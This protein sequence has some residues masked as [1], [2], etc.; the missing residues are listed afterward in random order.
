MNKTI[1]AF[2]ILLFL[3]TLVSAQ[4]GYSDPSK[5]KL[6]APTSNI[7]LEIN[8]T[9]LNVNNSDYLDGYHASAFWDSITGNI[10]TIT[11]Y[12]QISNNILSPNSYYTNSTRLFK[13]N[14][15]LD[16]NGYQLNSQRSSNGI[17]TAGY[18]YKYYKKLKQGWNPFSILTG[19]ATL[20][21]TDRN[22]TVYPGV[23]MIGYSSEISY[24]KAKVFYSYDGGSCYYE[25]CHALGILN[26]TELVTTQLS[27]SGMDFTRFNPSNAYSVE[28]S[29][30]GNLTFFKV[31]GDLTT[32][33]YAWSDLMFRDE[34]TGE[35]KNVTDAFNNGNG[36]IG[37][38]GVSDVGYVVLY[39][40][41]EFPDDPQSTFLPITTKSGIMTSWEG[42][43]IW[44]KTENIT[45]LRQDYNDT[46]SYIKSQEGFFDTININ[47]CVGTGCGSSSEM[48]YTNIAMQNQTNKFTSNQQIDNSKLNLNN[49]K[50]HMDNGTSIYSADIF[51]AT[52]T[53]NTAKS[54]IYILPGD[55][56]TRTG[57]LFFGNASHGFYSLNF[58]GVS[59]FESVPYRI[60]QTAKADSIYCA[61]TA[62]CATIGAQSGNTVIPLG[63][64]GSLMATDNGA[65]GQY[66]FAFKS[67]VNLTSAYGQKSQ[68]AFTAYKPASQCINSTREVNHT[69]WYANN[70]ASTLMTLDMNGNLDIAGNLT[71]NSKLGLTQDILIHNSTADDCYMNFT[72]GILTSTT[73]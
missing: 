55:T 53:A 32:D 65:T 10:S 20:D 3:I 70:G 73:C 63:N 56:S 57:R 6:E 30:D 33:T 9:L 37:A 35:V 46:Q 60:I 59:G 71:A 67:F 18:D 5:P 64:G 39:W 69:T 66:T 36:W 44:G 54:A 28:A 31:G 11:N 16:M 1:Y 2:V 68:F 25:H 13:L 34:I 17:T 22:I 8:E 14:D 7:I 38:P 47:N 41:R 23:N 51:V 42:Y 27:T 15:N 29:Y 45:L 24:P 62:T 61:Q 19:N 26:I 48:N 43:F 4:L 72:G 52:D 50:L 21:F 40:G 58:A 12:W 49:S